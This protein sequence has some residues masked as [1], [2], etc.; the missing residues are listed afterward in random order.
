MNITSKNV[1]KRVLKM[2]NECKRNTHLGG[3]LSIVELLT[4]LYRDV[5]SYDFDNPTWEGRDRFILSK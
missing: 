1:R 5:L 4:V 2:A 3:A